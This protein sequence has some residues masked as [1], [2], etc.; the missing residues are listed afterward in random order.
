M[1]PVPPT[2]RPFVTLPCNLLATG[3]ELSTTKD[4][5]PV[6]S[7]FPVGT[8]KRVCQVAARLPPSDW[9]AR[10][11]RM[12]LSP[13]AKDGQWMRLRNHRWQ[14]RECPTEL[15]VRGSIGVHV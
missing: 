5:P 13:T 14:R 15:L 3:S 11:C 7:G 2:K 10:E 1:R 9:V 4:P 6:R 8:P 12:T